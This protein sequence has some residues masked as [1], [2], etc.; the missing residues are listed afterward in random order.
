M[1]PSTNVD[2]EIVAVLGFMKNGGDRGIRT[3]NLCDANAALS[4]LSYIP[5]PTVEIIPHMRS[6]INYKISSLSVTD[7]I[8]ILKWSIKGE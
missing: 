2:R 5:T 3:P 4:L 1:R 8:A 7:N 6:Y